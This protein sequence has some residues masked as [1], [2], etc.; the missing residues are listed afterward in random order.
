[1]LNTVSTSGPS[2]REN[3]IDLN[4]FEISSIVMVIGCFVPSFAGLPGSVTSTA[5]ALNLAS[6]AFSLMAAAV[7]ASIFSMSALA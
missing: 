7:S 2:D 5:S 3:P 4:I 6:L 1:M